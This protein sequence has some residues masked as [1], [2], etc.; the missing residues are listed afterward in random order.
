V[1]EPFKNRI[2]AAAID[3]IAALVPGDWDRLGFVRQAANGLDALEL[4]DRVNQ[5]ADAL[6]D[7]LPGPYPAALDRIL[8]GL[9][10][11]P[12][13]TDALTEAF[14]LWPLCSFVE[15]HGLAHPEASL[16]AMPHLTPHWSCEFAIRPFYRD[17]ADRV[18]AHLERWV[19]HDNVHVRRLVSEGTR[20]RLPWGIRLQNRIDE[21]N[22]MLP[23]LEALRDDPSEYVR[24][25]VAN[26]LNDIAKDHPERLVQ[27]ARSWLANVPARHAKTRERLVRHAL[28]TQIKAGDP[29]AFA[30]IGLTPFEGTV[31]LGLA[32]PSL[33]IGD[34]LELTVTLT[35]ATDRTQKVRL[36]YAIHY[37]RKNGAH[38][39]RV[40]KL[41]ERTIPPG[42]RVVVQKT[43][44]TRVVSTRRLYP[45]LH[46]VDL[47]VNG[48]PTEP[49]DWT[50]ALDG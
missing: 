18:H 43:H 25:S 29:A 28:R 44:Q 36:D 6:H 31:T 50:L 40:F 7:R 49:L 45:G 30:L 3:R 14:E 16:A 24:R 46:R 48:T 32:N 20:P 41:G 37:L 39:A 34:P 17:D 10:A 12:D 1:A 38:S 33:A 8:S 5:V 4:K 26:H 27:I 15:R 2:D 47:R 11:P 35:S 13:D 42:A 19:A 23:L 22:R 9:S 21:P